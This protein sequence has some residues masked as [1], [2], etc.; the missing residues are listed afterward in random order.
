MFTLTYSECQSLFQAYP[1]F[2]ANLYDA[3]REFYKNKIIDSAP[4]SI[5]DVWIVNPYSSSGEVRWKSESGIHSLECP[6]TVFK[7][8]YDVKCYI[9]KVKEDQKKKQAIKEMSKD[10]EYNT[11]LKLKNK[12]ENMFKKL[13]EKPQQ[14][15]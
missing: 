10:P 7:D 15:D 14:L 13:I 8:Q 4:T 11:Y 6:L 1:K 3:L 9:E 2:Q 12:F 5:G